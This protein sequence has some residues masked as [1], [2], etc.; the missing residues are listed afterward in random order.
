MEKSFGLVERFTVL[1]RV[2]GFLEAC[3]RVS[4]RKVHDGT[5]K[6]LHEQDTVMEAVHIEGIQPATTSSNQ[7]YNLIS[8]SADIWI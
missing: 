6:L 8:C 3:E 2:L 5:P 7:W 4:Y 1:L